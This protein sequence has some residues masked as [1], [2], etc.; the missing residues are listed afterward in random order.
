MEGTIEM[1]MSYYYY[2]IIFRDMV[3]IIFRDIFYLLLFKGFSGR[4]NTQCYCVLLVK[5]R[6][7]KKNNS[8]E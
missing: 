1:Q 3:S 7:L 5:N 8:V 2:G 6:Q 4:G